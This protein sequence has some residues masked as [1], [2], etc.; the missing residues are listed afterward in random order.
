MR[1]V[2]LVLRRVKEYSA[3]CCVMLSAHY[4][5]AVTRLHGDVGHAFDIDISF[6]CHIDPMI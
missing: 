4:C 6:H 1:D 3:H 2:D 5:S